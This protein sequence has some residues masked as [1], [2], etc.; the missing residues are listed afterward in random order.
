M[1]SNPEYHLDTRRVP[2]KGSDQADI[3]NRACLVVKPYNLLCPPDYLGY[4]GVFDDVEAYTM[5]SSP[6]TGYFA[7]IRLSN[8]PPQHWRILLMVLPLPP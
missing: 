6:T 8:R 4:H 2:F 5:S 7:S 3:V 1:A